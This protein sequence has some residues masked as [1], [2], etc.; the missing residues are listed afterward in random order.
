[1]KLVDIIA[2]ARPNFIKVSPIIKS[3]KEKQKLGNSNLRFRL[4]HTGQHYDKKMSNDFFNQLGIPN[5]N[6]N[7]NVGS[8]S[9]AEQTSAIMIAYEKLLL[10]K[11]SDL[12]LVVGDV[13][14]TL[15]CSISAKKLSIPVAH[16]EAGLRSGDLSMPEEINRILTDSITD[17]FF[18]TSSYANENLIRSG[19]PS[20]NIFFVG[21]TMIDTLKENLDKL[22]E[23][24]IIKTLNKKKYLVLTLHRPSNVDNSTNLKNILKELSQ[25]A[26][27]LE[28]LFPVHP[29]TAKILKKINFHPKNVKFL[30]PLSYLEFIFIVKNSSAVIT[31]SGGITEETTYL[32]I[33]C[34]TLRDSTE[35]PETI[36]V[37][38]N[39]LLG[40][41][42]N[43]LKFYLKKIIEGKW[44]K[45]K[46]PQKW[47]GKTSKRIVDIIEKKI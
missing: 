16:V 8:G 38:T 44:K 21:N 37:G 15:A 29:R 39:K 31:D 45:G 10:K 43:K 3:L 36:K 2:G 27:G 11:P 5:P 46:I 24:K 17:F 4:I 7:F 42:P 33:P 35:R 12:C 22:I 14:S 18:T 30:D 13:N 6:I 23:P 32:K 47:D 41:N 19:V 25:A 1:M 9:Q 26:K 20:K 40:R 28:I 34:L